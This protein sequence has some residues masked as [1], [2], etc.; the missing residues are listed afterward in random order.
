MDDRVTLH[1]R[2]PP[3]MAAQ[4]REFA[5]QSHRSISGAL[6]VLIE[7]GLCRA[8][9]APARAGDRLGDRAPRFLPPP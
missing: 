1:V 8:P 2:V 3:G 7:S 6:V 5:A 9:A 4:V